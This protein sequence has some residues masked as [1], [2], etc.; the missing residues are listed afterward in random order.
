MDKGIDGLSLGIQNRFEAAFNVLEPLHLASQAVGLFAHG[1]VFFLQAVDICTQ[2]IV[3]FAEGCNMASGRQC[4][5]ASS[6]V[7]LST[8]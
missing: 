7:I 5:G 6:G 1:I 8:H 2:S 4:E 3:D